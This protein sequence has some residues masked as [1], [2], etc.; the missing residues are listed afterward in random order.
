MQK[1]QLCLSYIIF[2]L[3]QVLSTLKEKKYLSAVVTEIGN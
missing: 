1:S 3:N 2:A